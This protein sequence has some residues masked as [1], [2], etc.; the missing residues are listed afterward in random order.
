M[1]ALVELCRDVQTRCEATLVAH[2]EW[3]CRKGCDDCCR[4]LAAVP[5]LSREEWQRVRQAIATLP[6]S[7]RIA[8]LHRLRN[9]ANPQ[10]PLVC[11]LL[12]DQTHACLIYEARPVACRTYGFYVERDSVLGCSRIEAMAQERSDVV[13]G[14]HQAIADRV[15][16]THDISEWL[17]DTD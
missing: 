12:D 1:T 7:T 11:P 3:P 2:P 14:N 6:E 15:G 4:N 17:G 16:P 5:R 13:W 9:L 10:R 8:V